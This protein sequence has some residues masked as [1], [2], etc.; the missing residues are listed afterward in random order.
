MSNLYVDLYDFIGRKFDF[1]YKK[2]SNVVLFHTCVVGMVISAELVTA[3]D[4]P[5]KILVLKLYTNIQG[6]ETPM[7]DFLEYSPGGWKL[8]RHCKINKKKLEVIE[9]KGELVWLP[10]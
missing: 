7:R 4:D 8:H 5:D 9:H 10:R 1:R 3:D 6:E 2:D